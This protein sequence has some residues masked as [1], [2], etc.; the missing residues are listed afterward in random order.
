MDGL[1]G[2]WW[3]PLR[4]PSDKPGLQGSADVKVGR[5]GRPLRA[6]VGGVGTGPH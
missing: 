6:N 4:A 1:P 2:S 3:W 5:D